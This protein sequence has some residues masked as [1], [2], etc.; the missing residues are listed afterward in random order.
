MASVLGITT[1]GSKPAAGRVRAHACASYRSA[2]ASHGTWLLG[3]HQATTP[4]FIDV[5][6]TNGARRPRGST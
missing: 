5:P 4:M 6:D 2:V 1:M 3:S